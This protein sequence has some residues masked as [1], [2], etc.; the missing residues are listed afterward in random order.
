[1]RLN[2]VGTSINT[3]LHISGTTI[4]KNSTT[5]SSSLNVSGIT[6]LN[7]GTITGTLSFGSQIANYVIYLWELITMYLVLMLEC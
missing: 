1:M 4:L 2:T 3:T 7:S 6:T 5:C